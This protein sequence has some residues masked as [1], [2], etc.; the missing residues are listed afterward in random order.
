MNN[1]NHFSS[2]VALNMQPL[3]GNIIELL[4]AYSNT[5]IE[6]DFEYLEDAGQVVPESESL[7]D[8]FT[9]EWLKW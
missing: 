7:W 9:P 2:S 1:H 4:D 5:S 6:D 3:V 8:K